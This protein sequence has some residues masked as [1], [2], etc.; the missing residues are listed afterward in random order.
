MEEI[1]FCYNCNHYKP[2]YTKGYFKFDRCD[3]GNCSQRKDTVEKH[4]TC[5]CYTRR[6]HISYNKK[7]AALATIKEHIDLLAEIKQILEEDD[8]ELL[9]YLLLEVKSRK[10]QK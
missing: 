6:S 4:E 2:Y 7:G 1:K 5:E 8:E 9:E 3:I 10:A